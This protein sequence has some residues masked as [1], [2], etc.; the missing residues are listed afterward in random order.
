MV[1]IH[2]GG[3][4]VGREIEGG[5]CGFQPKLRDVVC[6]VSANQLVA[7][8]KLTISAVVG[9][10]MTTKSLPLAASA[11]RKPRNNLAA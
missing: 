6:Q 7:I 9:S 8:S 1:K 11:S 4:E 3:L 2:G 10:K 5:F